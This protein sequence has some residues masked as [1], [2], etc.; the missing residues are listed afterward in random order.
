MSHLFF[1]LNLMWIVQTPVELFSSQWKP[2]STVVKTPT[3]KSSHFGKGLMLEIK[4]RTTFSGP[5][6]S[7]ILEVGSQG[8]QVMILDHFTQ[9]MGLKSLFFRKKLGHTNCDKQLGA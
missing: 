5:S 3:L 2:P 4:L 6:V 8:P 9:C 7:T 1:L